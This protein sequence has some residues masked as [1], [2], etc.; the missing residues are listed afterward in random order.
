MTIVEI[1]RDM[2]KVWGSNSMTKVMTRTPETEIEME[3]AMETE[4]VWM[5]SHHFEI[6]DKVS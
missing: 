6:T 4:M 2:L 3:I 1:E 5:V